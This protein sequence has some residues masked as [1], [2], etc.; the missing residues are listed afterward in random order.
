[1]TVQ[2]RSEQGSQAGWTQAIHF[3]GASINV[4]VKNH[5]L[6]R[7][8][9]WPEALAAFQQGRFDEA[10]R[11]CKALLVRDTKHAGAWNL[12]GA[13]ALKQGQPADALAPLQKAVAL[14]PDDVSFHNNLGIAYRG[15]GRPAE[16]E[17]SYRRA[18]ALVPTYADGWFNLGNVLRDLGRH[19]EAADAFR[20]A[21]DLKPGYAA[22]W[23]NLGNT[24]RALD[25][26]QEAVDTYRRALQLHDDPQTRSNLAYALKEAGDSDSSLDSLR[27]AV[28]AEP[29]NAA[30]H[31]NLANALRDAN[32]PDAAIEHY[33][34]AL[35]LKP[36][37]AAAANNLGS[38]L[39]GRGETLAALECYRRAVF[40]EATNGDY[41]A[42]AGNAERSL[43]RYPQAV[44]A[45]RA[46]SALKPEFPAYHYNLGNT[47]RE[48][49]RQDPTAAVT[50]ADIEAAYRRAIELKGDFA[51]A[52]NNLGGFYSD[53][54]RDEAAL[55]AYQQALAIEPDNW[56]YQFN[57]AQRLHSSGD[58]DGARTAFAAGLALHEHTG[59]RIRYETLFP[60]IMESEAAVAETRAA[61]AAGLAGLLEREVA[62]ADP[63]TDIAVAPMF[64]LAY[65]GDGNAELMRAYTQLIRR[66]CPAVDYI[67]PHCQEGRAAGGK[68]RIGFASKFFQAHT[69]GRFFRGILRH[70]NRDLFEIFAFMTP[71]KQDDVTRWIAAHVDCFE[72]LPPTLAEARERVAQ[73]R[74]DIL[75][76]ADIGMEP[77]TYYLA[78]SRLAPVQCVLY[79]HP[80]TTGIPTIDYFL[81][82]GAC[83]APDADTH[84]TETLVRLDPA[85]TYT[86]YYRPENR[87]V[88]KTRADLGLPAQGHLYTC[89]QS[90]FKI[91]PEMDPVFD[92]LLER[93]PQ[94]RLLL[95]DDISQRRIALFK[96]RLQG[97]MRHFDRVVF[98]SRLQ[99]PDF[100]QVLHLSAALLDSFHFCGGNTS[101][102]SFAAEAP[103]VT[104]PGRFMRGRQTLGLYQRMGFTE[105][106]AADK[107]DYV[108]KTLRLANDA[109]YA[110]AVRRELAQRVAVIYEDVGVVRALER[111]FIEVVQ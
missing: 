103:V 99:L 38:V 70:L 110:R 47:L 39:L 14:A 8:T 42:N 109:D 81:S 100:L 111:F 94:G 67:A 49:Q 84:Y 1:M 80:D 13:M 77:F 76:Y 52:W 57:L 101:F 60:A 7:S 32:E 43:R 40:F 30:L 19:E 20:R 107:A 73:H 4:K 88:H 2:F 22:A 29:G 97:R 5:P 51:D 87:A 31:Y 63:M 46:A 58:I 41:L 26:P 27:K 18:L 59:A 50:S 96:R 62:I 25:R 93:D 104:L 86:Y 21:T 89:A 12:L 34:H 83:E 74:L 54:S 79:G 105:L 85:S 75:V 11:L 72:V 65:H 53:D 90:M 78:F 37:Y 35:I 28:A 36:D 3:I 95:F 45:L 82:G 23:N 55:A 17:Q 102:D 6:A 68:I 92:E 66:A 48:W 15:A 91:H 9:H 44:E 24:L 71:T 98:L 69:I 10:A 64:Y 56:R 33:R 108:A 61:L 106:V 16:A